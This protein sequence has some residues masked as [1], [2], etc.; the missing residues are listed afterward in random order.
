MKNNQAPSSASRGELLEPVYRSVDARS[1]DARRAI[2]FW[3]ATLTLIAA[4]YRIRRILAEPL[5]VP[6]YGD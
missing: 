4:N 1:A 6:P 2:R 5:G 3:R